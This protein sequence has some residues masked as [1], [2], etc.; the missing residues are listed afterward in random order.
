[1][2]APGEPLP[3]APPPLPQGDSAADRPCAWPR[4]E[5]PPPSPG[6]LDRPAR[7]VSTRA[8]APAAPAGR[9]TVPRT[10]HARDKAVFLSMCWRADRTAKVRKANIRLKEPT[11]RRPSL[12]P[13]ERA[14]ENEA[15]VPPRV[16][17]ASD[18]QALGQQV[19]AAEQASFPMAFQS[20]RHSQAASPLLSEPLP[21][22][23]GA[24]TARPGRVRG[25]QPP[26]GLRH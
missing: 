16:P 25:G 8:A 9:K 6:R 7:S 24:V 14:T 3:A 12:L 15:P 20:L 11:L 21:R 19:G 13:G 23:R 1:M 26:A 4:P 22:S 18:T 5:P 2:S 10:A 17:P